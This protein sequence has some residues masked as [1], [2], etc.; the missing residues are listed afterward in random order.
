MLKLE[1][2]YHLYDFRGTLLR[3]EQVERFKQFSWR[4]RPPSLLSKDQQ[5]KIRKNLREYSRM[6]DEVDLAKKDSANRAVVEMRRRLLDEWR[7]WRKATTEE[8]GLPGDDDVNRFANNAG[9]K[10]MQNGTNGT[11]NDDAAETVEEI[12]EEIVEETEEVIGK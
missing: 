2:G 6:F 11:K 3:E 8:L 9:R 4:P 1:N 5:K 7:A 12:V 10:M